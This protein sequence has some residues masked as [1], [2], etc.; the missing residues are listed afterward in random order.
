MPD[1]SKLFNNMSFP[2]KSKTRELYEMGLIGN[3]TVAL[4][5]RDNVRHVQ[6]S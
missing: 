2:R 6:I 1:E 4:K 5:L 3:T